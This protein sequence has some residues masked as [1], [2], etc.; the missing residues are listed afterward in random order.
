MN[1]YRRKHVNSRS[2]VASDEKRYAQVNPGNHSDFFFTPKDFFA[3]QDLAAL[4]LCEHTIVTAGSYGWWAAWLAEGG[5]LHDLNYLVP[6]QN[7][8]KETYFPPWFLFSSVPSLLCIVTTN[9]ARLR[10]V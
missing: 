4:A 7:C 5:V 8:V 6:F 9:E 1:Y 2:L 10:F 3:G